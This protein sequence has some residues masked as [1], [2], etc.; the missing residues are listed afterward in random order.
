MLNTS[1]YIFKGLKIA[2]WIIFIGLCIEA[3]GLV[4]NFI[5][6]LVKPEVVSNLYPELDITEIYERSRW[7]FFGVYS[8][9]LVISVLKAYLFYLVIV[10]VTKMDLSK[11]FNRLVAKQISK[12]SYYTFS[13]GLLSYI[14]RQT[15][16]NLQH[17]GYDVDMLSQFWADSRA[18]I[19]M[20][21][22]IYI[23][24]VIFAK[25]VDNQEELEETV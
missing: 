23:I 2:A 25:G 10:L 24:A 20:A 1:N 9:I 8:F 14:A 16:K 22:V 17:R 4:L 13:I 5:F 19:L 3:G 15:T 21:A 11:P 7:S 6:S 12:I 18:F